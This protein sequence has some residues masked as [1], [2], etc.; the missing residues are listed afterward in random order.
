MENRSSKQPEVLCT[1][2]SN[3][4]LVIERKSLLWPPDYAKLHRAEHRFWELLFKNI[5]GK[6]EGNYTICADPIVEVSDTSIEKLVRE[7][8]PHILPR[9]QNLRSG[10][11]FSIPVSVYMSIRK[12]Y[13]NERDDDEPQSGIKILSN[14]ISCTE[15]NNPGKVPSE[16]VTAI[17]KLMLS[18]REKMSQYDTSKKVLILNYSS[19]TLFFNCDGDWWLKYL[20]TYVSQPFSFNELWLSFN[21][22]NENWIFEQ[23]WPIPS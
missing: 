8:L 5:G 3:N 2:K 10:Q 22:E 17:D 11:G 12:E 14:E 15:L 23:V 19:A 7:I 4:T 9:A 18:V 13:D 16:F 20:T 1:N 6:L 21:Y